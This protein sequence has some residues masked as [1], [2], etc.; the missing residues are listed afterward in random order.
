[1]N[2]LQAFDN[3]EFGTIRTCL[4]DD[5]PWAVGKDVALALGY[6]NPQK[7]VRAHVDDEDRWV[8]NSFTHGV[9]N[10]HPSITDSA[11]RVQY[12]IW[13]NESGLYSL[14]LSCKL[15]AAKKFKRWVT[16]EVLPSLRRTGTYTMPGKEASRVLTPDDYL[17][18]ARILSGCRNERM[19]YVVPLLKKAGIDIRIDAEPITARR[20]HDPQLAA[21]IDKAVKKR[22]VTMKKL[23]ELTGISKTQLYRMRYGKSLY[24][25][26]R[27]ALLRDIIQDLL[28]DVDLD[29][30]LDE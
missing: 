3:P 19:P 29:E 14:I 4:I 21:L 22:I 28:P 24:N 1:M 27:A 7:A 6:A 20:G 25:P 5:M 16:S 26:Q 2:E 10:V 30:L 13:I 23:E 11:G 18:A 8:T 17:T 12:P 9:Q 15:P